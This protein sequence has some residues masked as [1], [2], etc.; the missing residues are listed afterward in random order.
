MHQRGIITNELLRYRRKGIKGLLSA[1][2]IVGIFAIG[3][4]HFWKVVWPV[5]LTTRDNIG[6]KNWMFMVALTTL[7]H[8]LWVLIANLIMA[9]VYKVEWNFFEQYKIN[10]NPWPWKQKGDELSKWK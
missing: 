7:W 1:I 5:V 2:I 9:L 10:P 8:A 6:C 3:V 4:P